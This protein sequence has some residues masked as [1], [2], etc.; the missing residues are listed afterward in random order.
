M[1]TEEK[2]TKQFA[3]IFIGF[4]V[5]AVITFFGY[6]F[7][8]TQTAKNQQLTVQQLPT[9]TIAFVDYISYQGVTGKTALDL[10]NS[11]VTVEQA[12]SGLVTSINGRKADNNSH[13]YWA[14]YINGK[15][16]QV[17][18]AE[19]ITKDGDKIEWKIEKY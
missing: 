16:A 6:G 8:T 5:F 12:T 9:P 13:E 11:H 18:P 7:F 17:G 4:L 14:F 2:Q 10:L 3:N 1:E 15:L 19:Y